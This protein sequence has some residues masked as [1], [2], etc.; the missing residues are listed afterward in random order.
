MEPFA[1]TARPADI[2]WGAAILG[3][4]VAIA[5]GAFFGTLIGNV[6]LRLFMADG[7]SYAQAWSAMMA[8]ILTPWAIMSAL[9]SLLTG[10][11]GG[12]VSAAFGGPR[13]VAQAA[14]ASVL[15]LLF[16]AVMY[17]NPSSQFGPMWHEVYEFGSPVLASMAGGYLYARRMRATST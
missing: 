4:C 3:G 13:A 17:F 9:M 16:L 12:Y 6:A 15:P 1:T 8:Y 2:S 14:W 5:G 7:L 10:L 11:A